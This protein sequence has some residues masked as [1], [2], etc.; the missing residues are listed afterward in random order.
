MESD[1]KYLYDWKEDW[2]RSKDFLKAAEANFKLDDF[3][4]AAN[5]AYFTA[6]SAIVAA[7]KLNSKPVSKSHKNIWEL[8][9]LLELEIDTYGLLRDL[10]DM[11][12]QADYGHVSYIAKLDK[13]TLNNYLTKIKQMLEII[14]KKYGI[15]EKLREIKMKESTAE[16]N[17]D[18]LWEEGYFAETMSSAEM[19]EKMRTFHMKHDEEM[20]YNCRK[21]NKKISAHNKDW[22]SGMC[23][24]CFNEEHYKK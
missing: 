13:E 5:R 4:T 14:T 19:K 3:K 10:Y 21:C 1:K 22:H 15:D 24:D 20:N 17:D 7:L 11:R 12:L 18:G 9:K 23:D 6:E 8:S 16:S 2:S